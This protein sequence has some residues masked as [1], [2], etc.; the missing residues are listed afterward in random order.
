M[1]VESSF[2]SDEYIC[3]RILQSNDPNNNDETTNNT[4]MQGESPAGESGRDAY[5]FV[6]FLLWYLFLVVCCV[7]PTCCAYRRRRLMEAR[8]A[9]QQ[10]SFDQLH[11]QN[12]FILSNLHL[13]PEMDAEEARVERTKRITEALKVTT[14]VSIY[15]AN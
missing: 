3:A 12:V 13:R 10:V 1:T 15:C 14:F 2:P 8:I 11:Q 6:A 7:L 4:S 9:Q 5:E